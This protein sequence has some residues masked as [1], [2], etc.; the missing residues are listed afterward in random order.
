MPR[1]RIKLGIANIR[2]HTRELLPLL[3]NYESVIAMPTIMVNTEHIDEIMADKILAFPTSLQDNQG[4]PVGLDSKKIRH[5]DIW[6]L[7]W[8]IRKGAKLKPELVAAK[9]GDY[10]VDGYDNMLVEALARI[11]DIVKSPPFKEQ[12]SRFIDS[13]TVGKMLST[14][15]HLNYFSTTVSGLFSRMQAELANALQSIQTRKLP[16]DTTPVNAAPKPKKRQASY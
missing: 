10:G 13:T 3:A 11:P 5:R 15:A 16:P 12:M 2:A 4:L 1:Q 14:D 6:D 7:A 9:V 8:L